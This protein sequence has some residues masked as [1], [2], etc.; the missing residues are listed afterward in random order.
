MDVEEVKERTK[1][2]KEQSVKSKKAKKGAAHTTTTKPS[3]KCAL[4]HGPHQIT[5]CKKWGETSVKDRWEVAK[6]NRLCYRCLSSGHQGKNCP[7]NN[8]C[9]INDC[10]GTHHFHL[11]FEQR[12][13]PLKHDGS[14]STYVRDDIITA[15]GLVAANER[16]FKLSTLTDSCVPLKSKEVMLTIKSLDGE[17]QSTVEA[18]TLQEMCQGLSIP[19]WNQHKIKWDHLKNI[20]FPKIPGRKTIDT[21]IGSDHPKLSLALSECYGPIEAPVARKTP[22]GWTCVGRLPALPSAKRIAFARTFRTQTLSETR[23]DEQ[24]QE[25]WD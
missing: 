10:K 11:H 12:P 7:K 8:L 13:N 16:N 3:H 17:T 15:L 19:D 5:S 4:C 25:M 22:L 2:K 21:L 20:T 1:K 18:W 9:G 24:L 6:E 23:L 14:D